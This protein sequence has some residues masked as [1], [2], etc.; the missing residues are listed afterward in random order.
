MQY[1]AVAEIEDYE[2]VVLDGGIS[3]TA[4]EIGLT[5]RVLR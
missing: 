5:T 3:Q 1:V 4:V 2:M